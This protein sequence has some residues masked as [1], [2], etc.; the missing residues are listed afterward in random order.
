MA[1]DLC[2]TPHIFIIKT[3]TYVKLF[4]KY[5]LQTEKRQNNEWFVYRNYNRCSFQKP[6]RINREKKRKRKYKKHDLLEF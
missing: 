5:Y 1:G 6:H 3:Y 4:K 2:T